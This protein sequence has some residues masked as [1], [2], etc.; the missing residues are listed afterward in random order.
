VSAAPKPTGRFDR[1]A[2][3]LLEARESADR[4]SSQIERT[5]GILRC[6]VPDR[7]GLRDAIAT[8]LGAISGTA[9]RER[10]KLAALLQEVQQTAQLR[11]R[12]TLVASPLQR[13]L[14][15]WKKSA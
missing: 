14:L 1:W 7:S 4:I 13:T 3:E 8:D 5:R 6:L 10:D 15:Q 12:L 2:A 9:R 11:G